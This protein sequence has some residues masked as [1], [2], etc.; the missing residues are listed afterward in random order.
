M[1]ARLHHIFREHYTWLRDKMR[2]HTGNPHGAED[3]AAE[4]FLQLAEH[5]ALEEVREPRALL[6]TIAKRVLFETWRR[7]DLEQAYLQTLAAAPEPTYPSP[8]ERAL[9]MEALLAVDAALDSLPAKARHAFL[10]SQLDA[11]TY[12][13][14]AQELGVSA[15]MVRQYMTRALSAIL[16][17]TA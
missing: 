3:V 14:I 13:E 17:A 10:R 1:Q 5:R 4:A 8:E 16:A 11:V 9:V 2:R 6:A 12:A 7:R 15:S